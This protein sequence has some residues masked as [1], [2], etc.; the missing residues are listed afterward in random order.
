MG[1][2]FHDLRYA[3]R[4]L[5]RQRVFTLLALTM[6]ALG[7]GANSAIFAVVNAVLL[8]PLPY[9]DPGRL[10]LIEDVIKSLSP[11]GM[12]VTP[13]D[14]VEYQ[15]SSQAFD[16][17]AGYTPTSVEFTG[18][19]PPER[20]KSVRAS[21]EIFPVLGVTPVIGRGFTHEQ[22]HPGSGVAVI[23]YRLWQRRFA[24]DAGVVGRVVDFNRSP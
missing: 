7:I 5:A 17:V 3:V 1:T 6:L 9:R 13:A 16:S 21:A 14:L 10:V 22:D 24:G 18:G 8:R 20:V 4:I 12:T 11:N 2:T 19:G 15:R 23:S